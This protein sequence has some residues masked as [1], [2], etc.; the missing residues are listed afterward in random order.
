MKIAKNSIVLFHHKMTDQDGEIIENSAG[1]EPSAFLYGHKN[2]IETLEHSMSGKEAGDKFCVTLQ[3]EMAY[4]RLNLKNRLRVARKS[5]GQEG[6]LEPGMIVPLKT[7][8]GT[9]PVTVAKVG[10]FNVDI[11]FNHPLAG[12]TL[13]FDIEIVDIRE[14][15]PEEIKQ[16]KPQSSANI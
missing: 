5:I 2:M 11:D 15:T 14:A 12:K 4:G 9:R 7:V 10:K 3:P 1:Q 16:G 13:T 6:K 8:E